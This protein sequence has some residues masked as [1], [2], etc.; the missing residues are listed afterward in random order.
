MKAFIP[1]ENHGKL[2]H[3]F[4]FSFLLHQDD[5]NLTAPRLK[6]RMLGS[7]KE[8]IIFQTL[9]SRCN[10]LVSGSIFLVLL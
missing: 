2:G 7:K 9:I 6:R 8:R 4:I 5:M 10:R 1:Q 3:E